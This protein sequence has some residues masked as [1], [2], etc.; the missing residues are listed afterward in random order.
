MKHTIKLDGI[1]YTLDADA[2]KK[3]GIL[4]PKHKTQM[5]VKVGD[6]FC[7][8]IHKDINEIEFIY[9]IAIAVNPDSLTVL[10]I[11]S[12]GVP[13]RIETIERSS[14]NAITFLELNMSGFSIKKNQ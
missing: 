1:E 13:S 2:A 10:R 14:D 6:I 11:D 7:R 3:A 9:S 5:D 4:T 12:C 8:G